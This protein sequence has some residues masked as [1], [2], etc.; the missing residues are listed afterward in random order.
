MFK[1]TAIVAGL[2]LALS[3]TAQAD[4]RFQAD[5]GISGGDVSSI[6][7]G[8]TAFLMPVDDSKGPLGEAAFIDQASSLSVFYSDGETD[9]D[10]ANDIELESYGIGGRYVTK[11]TGSWIVDLAYTR[12]EPGGFEVDN[13]SIGVGKYLWDTTTLVFS[14]S[15]SDADAGGDVD[16]YRVDVDHLWT[17]GNDG[18]LKLHGAYGITDIDDDEEFSDNDDVDV[19]EIDATWYITRNF[20]IG[21]GYSNTEDGGEELEQYLAFA[22]Y[23]ITDSVSVGIAYTE[24]E[25]EDTDFETDSYVFTASARF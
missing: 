3:A 23:F 9:V 14:Y 22:E 18:G 16:S 10:S 25:V 8:G 12:D 15:N 1:K 20:G 24:A 19:Y 7:L 11:E 21:G 6:T 13:Y 5:A 2:G 17:F 4:Y